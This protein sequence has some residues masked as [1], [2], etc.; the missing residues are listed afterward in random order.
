MSADALTMPKE[1]RLTKPLGAPV[2]FPYDAELAGKICEAIA[3]STQSLKDICRRKAFGISHQTFRKWLLS[4]DELKKRY[5]QARQLQVHHLVEQTIEIAD[6][7]GADHE[8]AVNARTGAQYIKYNGEA[9]QRSNT[10]INA[11]QWAASKLLPHVYG[12][13]LDVTSGGEPL[14][15]P[16]PLQIDARVQ[17]IMLAVAQ[18]RD[19][20]RLLED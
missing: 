1:R 8:I 19:A 20:A 4:N 18:R 2:Q 7:S 5:A 6:N 13:K 14:P 10:R 15:A 3:C 12:D 9:V 17:T 11:R 16:S